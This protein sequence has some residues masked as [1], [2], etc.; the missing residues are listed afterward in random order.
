[1]IPAFLDTTPLLRHLT[2]DHPDHSPRATAYLAR[3]EHGEI[4]V[5]TTDTVVFEAVFLL[6]KRYRHS[7]AA[8]RD[9]VLPLLELP[10]I[11]L[12]GKS[13]LRE[14]FDLYVDRN[15]PFADAYHV[16]QMRRLGLTEIVSFDRD[17]DR[18]PGIT[19]I[20]P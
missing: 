15:L 4:E 2:N 17:Y 12:P 1:M 6:E 8:I 16:V 20:E 18:V 5:H 14:V 19:R 10:G 13:H 9:T 11:I 7:K 3:V